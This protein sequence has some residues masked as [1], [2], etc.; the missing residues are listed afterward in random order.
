MSS[1]DV[2][3]HRPTVSQ[4]IRTRLLVL[5]LGLTTISVVTVGY[6]GVHSVQSVGEKAQQ[7][8][9][10]ALRAQTEKCLRQVTL[11]DSQRNDLILKEVQQDAANVAQYTAGIFER[12]DVF[13]SGAYWQAVDRMFT[14]PNGQYMNDETDVSNAF[15]PNLVNVDSEL[16]KVLDLSAYLD[17]VLVPTYESSPNTVAIYL[18]TKEEILRYY[19]NINIG[20]VVPPDFRVT[21][22]PWYVSA[23]PENN[24]ERTLV[25]SPT[26][27]D[28]TGKGLM[29]TA[30]APVYTSRDEFVGVVGIDVTLK[31]IGASVEAAQLPGGGYSFLID[32][33]GHAIVLPEQ[34]YQDILGRSPEPEEFGTELSEVTTEFAPI[35][36]KMVAGK[37]GFDTLEV[38]EKE[39]F[40]AYAPLESTGWSLAN[41]VE[42]ETVLQAI[43]DFQKELETS[44]RSLMVVRILPVGGIISVVMTVTG[45]LLTH[46]LAEPIRQ[47]AA[48]VQRIGAGQ[49]DV[50]LPQTGNDEIGVLSQA[51]ATMTAQ[52]RELLE[53][54]EQRV[55]E[56]T[57]DLERRSVQLGAAAQV[58]REA[59]AIRDVG[60]LLDATV[61]LISERFGF[62]HAGI[63]LLDE[64]GEYAILRA[65][66][67]EGGERMLTRGHKL[68]VG[69]VGIVGYVASSG[70]PRVVLDVGEDAV[71]F[72]NPDLPRT[73][74]EMAL[75]LKV[76][77]QVIGI[78]DV[79]STEAAAFSDDDVGVLQTLGDQ[80]ALAIENARLLK[81]AEER[82]QD[83]N[84][85]LG[86]H[87]QEGWERLAA[88]RSGWGYVYDGAEV[89]PREKARV[90]GDGH[91]L[92]APLQV[93]GK[94]IGHLDLV[95]GEQPPTPEQEA[96]VQAVA[97]QTSLALENARLYY[98]TQRHAAREQLIGEV[99]ARMRETLD[100][101]MVLQTA[102]REMR[103]AMGLHDV[104]IRLETREKV[105]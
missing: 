96:V 61:H 6:L 95:M 29:V 23:D 18:G 13:A 91:Q 79:Q 40:V 76:Q 14:G 39:S 66:S 41:V 92:T 34:G 74:S 88:Q 45:L 102:V 44:T 48:A 82:L 63:F 31:N 43:G 1:L 99:T 33:T 87:G 21:Q 55:A 46:R 57:R 59:A 60:Q 51:F 105:S 4:S 32:N 84:V 89:V 17:F 24:P 22:R 62:Y 5:L 71:F 93:R 10:E 47:M 3:R 81:E 49:W 20:A 97:D 52:L 64:A 54:M 58:A 53:G 103:E 38:G 68:K 67:S 77:D 72:D 11:G 56:R 30:A 80:L 15:V 73:R 28:A 36:A 42:A 83:V 78:L 86:R 70:K 25:W 85:L 101:E 8:S 69:E 94:V 16:L 2:R 26:Y 7:I 65:A 19:P 75:P 98:D 9:A 27:V 35:L 50:S 90:A 100:V 104:M 37:T 12:P